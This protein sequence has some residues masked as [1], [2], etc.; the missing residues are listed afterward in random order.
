[1]VIPCSPGGTH[2]SR[3]GQLH[4]QVCS[5]CERGNEASVRVPVGVTPFPFF[6]FLFLSNC[7]NLETSL[8]LTPSLG[9]GILNP[10][11]HILAV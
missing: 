8:S 11:S 10:S 7:S 4:V 2:R 1:M 6:L 5:A 9:S 3:S